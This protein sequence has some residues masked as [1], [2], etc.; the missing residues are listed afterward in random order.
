MDQ[1]P[2]NS[3]IS[4][5]I[6]HSRLEAFLKTPLELLPRGRERLLDRIITIPHIGKEALARWITAAVLLSM[7]TVVSPSA[8]YHFEQF[9]HPPSIQVSAQES[10]GQIT[11]ESP[12]EQS[13]KKSIAGQV[14]IYTND[15]VRIENTLQW[16]NMVKQIVTDPRLD[17]PQQDRQYWIQT[18]LK[19]IFV[20][21]GGNSK[22]DSRL[23]K[24][25]TQLRPTTAKEAAEQYQIPGYDLYNPWDNTFLGLALQ[26]NLAEHFGKNLSLWAHHLGYGN[27]EEAIKT[28]LI[29]VEKLRM[30]EV[31]KIFQS[32]DNKL[33]RKYIEEY[34]ITLEKLLT[35]PAVTGKLKQ[36]NAFE[37]QT[38]HYYP[39]LVAAGKAMG[40]SD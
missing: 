37:D 23:A 12:R 35:S 11:V 4:P 34:G 38:E 20:E 1:N 32:Q 21:S 25:L 8:S 5:D 31:N 29:S 10:P 22:A 3:E 18:M 2:E 27:M 28:Y 7:I 17:I 19:I 14:E 16:K 26:L 6:I 24:G 13:L 39:R 9:I 40:F 15:Q 33:L 36:I 30:D